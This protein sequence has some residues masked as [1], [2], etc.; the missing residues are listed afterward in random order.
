MA[1]IGAILHRGKG[2]IAFFSRQLAPRHTNL[3]AYEWERSAW[4][5]KCGTSGRTCGVAP[6]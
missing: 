5:K 3:A 4:F 6:S 1:S 2:V